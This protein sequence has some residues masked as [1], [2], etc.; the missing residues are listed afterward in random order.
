MRTHNRQARRARLCITTPPTRERGLAISS[1]RLALTAD[2]ADLVEA[3]ARIADELELTPELVDLL[4]P[5]P[6]RH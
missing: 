6:R 4:L 2:D 3:A 1:R 5:A